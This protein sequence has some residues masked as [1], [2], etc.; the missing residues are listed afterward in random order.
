[1]A[2]SRPAGDLQ[3]YSL[4]P[5]TSGKTVE[6]TLFKHSSCGALLVRI[7]LGAY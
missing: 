2:P 4:S 7:A 3:R 1:M 5:G 6:R